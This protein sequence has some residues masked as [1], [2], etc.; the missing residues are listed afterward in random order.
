MRAGDRPAARDAQC[1]HRT[2]RLWTHVRDLVRSR[3]PCA[4]L[5][6]ST[7][8]GWVSAYLNPYFSNLGNQDRAIETG[9]RA[10]TIARASSD[11]ALEMMATFFL[12][13]RYICP[14]DYQQAAHY[15]RMNVDAHH[16]LEAPSRLR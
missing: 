13:L 11:F 5:G 16:G 8:V 4:S 15:H 14:G 1:A 9:R 7:P 6:G 12:G 2:W 10:L 3:S